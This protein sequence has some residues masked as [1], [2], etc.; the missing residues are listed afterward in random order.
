MPTKR[1]KS[2]VVP[3]ARHVPRQPGLVVLSMHALLCDSGYFLQEK[4]TFCCE[5]LHQSVKL[6]NVVKNIRLRP[7]PAAGHRGDTTMILV[8]NQAEASHSKISVVGAVADDHPTL[9]RATWGCRR[10][11]PS[12][13][14]YRL[15]D[16]PLLRALR[17]VEEVPAVNHDMFPKAPRRRFGVG[18]LNRPINERCCA[19]TGILALH[20]TRTI[21]YADLSLVI[22]EKRQNS[23]ELWGL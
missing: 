20:T 12:P 5:P 4:W 3:K 14:S 22:N 23:A 6:D 15:V 2:M 18:G 19:S 21:V 9:L 8:R 11:T 7:F 13:S 16:R 17:L 1:A 10:E